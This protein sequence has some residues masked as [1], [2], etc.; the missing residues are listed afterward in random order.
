MYIDR[1]TNRWIKIGYTRKRNREKEKGI[2]RGEMDEWIRTHSRGKGQVMVQE[3][4]EAP[5]KQWVLVVVRRLVSPSGRKQALTDISWGGQSRAS[6][7]PSGHW[8]IYKNDMT[9]RIFWWE[10]LYSLLHIWKKGSEGLWNWTRPLS[11]FSSLFNINAR[12]DQYMGQQLVQD[13]VYT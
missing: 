10:T 11:N 1:N 13:G 12:R 3:L 6:S 7:P 2:E 5:Q 9:S 8:V 4:T